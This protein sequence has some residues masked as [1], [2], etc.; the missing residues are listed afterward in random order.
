MPAKGVRYA[1]GADAGVVDP[2]PSA[3]TAD[4]AYAAGCGERCV[5]PPENLG[6]GA[7]PSEQAIGAPEA[8]AE[9]FCEAVSG[10]GSELR[11]GAVLLQVLNHKP[12][13]PPLCQA[14]VGVAIHGCVKSGSMGRTSTRCDLTPACQLNNVLRQNNEWRWRGGK[15]NRDLAEL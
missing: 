1:G 11:K 15:R 9:G 5:D 12:V 4:R 10:L 2:Q 7:L 6:A 3:F 14:G 8:V 13:A